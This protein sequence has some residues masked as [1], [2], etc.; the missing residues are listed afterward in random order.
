M[1]AK[2]QVEGNIRGNGKLN[3]PWVVYF[4][5][6]SFSESV[7]PCIQ[8]RYLPCPIR[9]SHTIDNFFRSTMALGPAKIHFEE[10]LHGTV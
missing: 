4:L 10:N 2:V 3:K 8:K 9:L 1:G 7:A 5:I 6:I